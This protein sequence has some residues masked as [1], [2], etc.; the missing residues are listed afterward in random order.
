MNSYDSSEKEC[1]Y[2]DNFTLLVIELYCAILAEKG[3]N[4]GSLDV[5]KASLLQELAS[6]QLFFKRSSSYRHACMA[7]R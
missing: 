1:R 4:S 5:I 7:K 2:D 3:I 6:G